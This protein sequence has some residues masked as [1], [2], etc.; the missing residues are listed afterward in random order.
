[1]DPAGIGICALLLGVFSW[2]LNTILETRS[3][4][5]AAGKRRFFL[6]VRTFQALAS[7][8]VLAAFSLIMRFF[9]CCI[10]ADRLFIFHLHHLATSDRL[11]RV[12]S[13]ALGSRKDCDGTDH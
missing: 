12:L 8:C 11:D 13:V 9:G 4:E 5:E 7:A 1:M 6:Q 3:Y 2:F 10:C